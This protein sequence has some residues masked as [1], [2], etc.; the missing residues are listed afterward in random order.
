MAQTLPA[1]EFENAV[2]AI[3]AEYKDL[4]DVDVQKVTASVAREAARAVSASAPVQTGA[5][6]KSIKA[7]ATEKSTNKATSVVYA[8]APQYRLTHLLEFGHAKVNGGRTTAYPHWEPAEQ[9]AIRDYERKLREA[10]E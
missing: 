2:N 3:L 10:I 8:E 1:S 5:Y 9:Q 6:K 4:I 7:K